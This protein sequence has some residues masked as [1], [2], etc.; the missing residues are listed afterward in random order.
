MARHLM[1]WGV[2][3]SLLAGCAGP[4][5]RTVTVQKAT[6]T[7]TFDDDGSDDWEEPTEWR[8]TD[9]HRRP[10]EFLREP[11]VQATLGYAVGEYDHETQGS[12]LDGDT[13]AGLLRF[14]AEGV[15]RPGF[16]G[17]VA[18]EFGASDDD[19]F[20][21]VSVTNGEARFFDAFIH[22]TFRLAPSPYFRMPVRVGP[23]LH[24]LGLEF[25]P[26]TDVTWASVGARVQVEPEVLVYR[27]PHAEV[28]I[29]TELTV[30]AHSTRVDR[31]TN[32]P[33]TDDE[34]DTEGYTAG[35][36]VGVRG[37]WKGFTAGLAYIHRT[38]QF[39]ES[40]PENGVFIREARGQF[41]GLMAE[42]GFSF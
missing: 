18:I 15:G 13:A 10:R 41:N 1:L 12:T 9:D 19:L 40:D 5:Q 30:G 36:S 24:A 39:D 31:D 16:G 38:M 25:D 37:R 28:G 20:D 11:Y 3:L 27:G 34:Y 8:R 42:M 32:N 26:N 4:L 6:D 29:F 33:L 21:D 17:G 22:A 14:T 7:P 23:Y 35:V 2:A